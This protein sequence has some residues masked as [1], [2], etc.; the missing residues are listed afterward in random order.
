MAKTVEGNCIKLQEFFRFCGFGKA[1]KNLKK[2]ACQL[3]RNTNGIS[4]VT[5][6]YLKIEFHP[7]FVIPAKA[8]IQ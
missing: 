1:K 3:I 8:G 6:T 4:V 7:A 5:R 2:F